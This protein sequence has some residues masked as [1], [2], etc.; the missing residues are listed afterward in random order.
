LKVRYCRT[1]CGKQN[2]IDIYLLYIPVLACAF[3][4]I[5][6]YGHRGLGQLRCGCDTVTAINAAAGVYVFKSGWPAG[7]ETYLSCEG[8]IHSYSGPGFCMPKPGPLSE[9]L[10]FQPQT[11]LQDFSSSTRQLCE[12]RLCRPGKLSITRTQGKIELNCSGRRKG[13]AVAKQPDRGSPGN[14]PSGSATLHMAHGSNHK[15]AFLTT[16]FC[17]NQPRVTTA[18]GK[19]KNAPERGACGKRKKQRQ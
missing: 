12:S 14:K 19:R 11:T 4:I 2:T 16:T 6:C 18:T 17:V 7:A 15:V 5:R 10:N 8:L 1:H 9:R 3:P 13:R